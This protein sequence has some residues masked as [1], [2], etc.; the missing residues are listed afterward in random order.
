MDQ[1]SATL[2]LAGTRERLIFM[3]ADHTGVCKFESAEGDDYLQVAFNLK[4]LVKSAVKATA[5]RARITSL[6]V[7]SSRSL[8]EGACM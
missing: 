4:R 5:E 3:N 1:K 6:S 8:P 2:G 7:L